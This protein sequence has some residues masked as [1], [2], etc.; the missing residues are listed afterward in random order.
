MKFQGAVIKEQG[1]TFGVL[2]VKPHVLND[3][4]RAAEMRRFGVKAWGQIPIVL[5]A[6][7]GRG[8]PTYNG[9]PDLVRFLANIFM[10][11]IPWQ[12]WNIAA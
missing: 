6:Q 3:S 5:M 9:K 1:V 10:E 4:T 8:R 2:V 11:Q 7:D 12:D